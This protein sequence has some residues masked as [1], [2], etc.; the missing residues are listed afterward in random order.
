MM[1]VSTKTKWLHLSW[2]IWNCLRPL[3]RR[4]L[5]LRFTF[6]RRHQ[7]S[8][9]LL[10]IWRCPVCSYAKA[11]QRMSDTVLCGVLENG[12]NCRASVHQINSTV[13]NRWLVTIEVYQSLSSTFWCKT[14]Q[15]IPS[16][17]RESTRIS[18]LP[19]SCH[20]QAHFDRLHLFWCTMSEICWSWY[21]QRTFWKCRISKH[22][23]N[24]YIRSTL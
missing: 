7:D 12:N 1:E 14:H 4:S 19:F 16:K 24:L 11:K 20:C 3:Y 9:L 13:C 10:C 15:R 2:W 6:S 18:N 22:D 21:T 5:R 23:T 8:A 17:R